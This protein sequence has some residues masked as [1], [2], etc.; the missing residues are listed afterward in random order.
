MRPVVIRVAAVALGLALIGSS[1][2]DGG[3]PSGRDGAGAPTATSAVAWERPAEQI[4]DL[5]PVLRRR[6]EEGLDAGVE[7]LADHL[8]EIDPASLGVV[9][10]LARNWGVEGLDG[11]GVLAASSDPTDHGARGFLLRPG[12]PDADRLPAVDADQESSFEYQ[13]LARAMYCDDVPLPQT[14]VKIA[15]RAAEGELLERTHVGYAIV[16]VREL[17]CQMDGL[18]DLEATVVSAL[19]QDLQSGDGIDD[20]S[21]TIGSALAYLGRS[22]LLTDAWVE[23]IVAA[24]GSD[25]GWSPDGETDDGSDWHPT[26]LAVWNLLAATRGSE[27]APMLQR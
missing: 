3:P 2:S 25:G 24:Q 26:G 18:D 17:G 15:R 16:W 19:T 20:A 7:Y 9:A 14:W 27:G 4:P 8:D 6:A 10:Y 12:H 5:D 23:R 11:A 22:D 13:V 21:L 1:C